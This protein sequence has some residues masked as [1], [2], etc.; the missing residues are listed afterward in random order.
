MTMVIQQISIG[1]FWFFND[2]PD[3]F[4]GRGI[5][6]TNYLQSKNINNGNEKNSDARTIA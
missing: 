1:T 2:Y 4:L 5:F 6:T 3:L